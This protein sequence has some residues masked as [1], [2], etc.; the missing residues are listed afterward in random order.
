MA[1]PRHVLSGHVPSRTEPEIPGTPSIP[2][3][4]DVLRAC[5]AE[6]I[7][8]PSTGTVE[9]W[10]WDY[11]CSTDLDT[12]LTPP[13][14]PSRWEVSPP[15]RR[16]ARPGRPPSL[17]VSQHAAKTPGPEAM[18]APARR[19]QLV[20]TFL[21][22]ELQA[23]E[24][25]AWALLAF[26]DSPR[27]FRGGLV[28]IALDEVR[29]MQMYSDYLA[30]L[31]HHFGDFPVR[32][33]FWERVPAAPTPAHFVAVMGVGFEGANL[34]HTARFAAR[35]RAIG[36][37]AGAALQERVSEEEIP[38]VRFALRWLRRWTRP[39]PEGPLAPADFSTWT[40]HL[41]PPLSPVLMRGKPLDLESRRRSGFPD[42]FLAELASWSEK[43]AA[44]GS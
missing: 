16:L 3:A 13:P 39:S 9:R 8:P 42:P 29:H 26:P 24:L 15:P 6:G 7:A 11:V 36:D 19:A 22:H 20:H 31:G 43:I 5:G 4:E 41:P 38:H 21:H 27:A 2:A 28:H 18:R 30:G 40:G 35:F 14:P 12:K 23:A 17:A 1:G 10:A 25:M 34:D 37:E 32:D 44:P 33:W